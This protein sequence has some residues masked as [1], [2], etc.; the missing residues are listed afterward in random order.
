MAETNPTDKP[1]SRAELLAYAAR[2]LVKQAGLSQADAEA[3]VAADR[4]RA[5]ALA[6]AGRA[7]DLEGVRTLLGD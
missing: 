6:E 4:Q 1:L 7:G 2:V 3:K 5:Q